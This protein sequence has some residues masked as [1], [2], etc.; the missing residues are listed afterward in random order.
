MGIPAVAVATTE[1]MTAARAQARALGR[2][3]MDAIYVPHPIQ[4]QTPG[5][6]HAR[7]AAVFAEIQ[8]RL[9]S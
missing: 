8:T 5:E 9:T 6:I 2:A 3:D 4:D 7:A 1:F